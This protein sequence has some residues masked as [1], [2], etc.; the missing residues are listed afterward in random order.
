MERRPDYTAHYHEALSQRWIA[1]ESACAAR[2]ARRIY[3]LSMQCHVGRD[4]THQLFD[5]G[6]R[7]ARALTLDPTELLERERNGEADCGQVSRLIAYFPEL[8]TTLPAMGYGLRYDYGVFKQFIADGWCQSSR[9][10]GTRRD[11]E[12]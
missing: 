8:R 2:N 12:G 6:G 7:D 5:A 10:A 1:A 3:P 11:K 4:A 9:F